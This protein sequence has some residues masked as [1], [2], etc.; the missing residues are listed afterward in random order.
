VEIDDSGLFKYVLLEVRVPGDQ[1]QRSDWGHGGIVPV[2][3]AGESGQ[4]A[5]GPTCQC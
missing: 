4:S 5:V 1:A 2:E 3:V